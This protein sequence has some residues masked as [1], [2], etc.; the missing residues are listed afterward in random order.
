MA[1]SEPDGAFLKE[2]LRRLA[3]RPLTPEDPLYV[4]LHIRPEA[5][6]PVAKI[7]LLIESAALESVQLFS[8]FK[9]SGKTTELFRL[10][11]TL[12]KKGFQVLYANAVEYLD[13]G[14]EIDVS[15][16][17]LAV[18]GGFSDAL[19]GALGANL[20]AESF[21][22]R[23]GNFLTMT[24][25]Q[26]TEITAKLGAKTPATGVLGGFEAGL[27][28]KM[29]LKTTPT[30]RRKLR[31]FLAA[32]LGELKAEVNRFVEDGVKLTREKAGKPNLPIVFLFDSFDQ[33]RGTWVNEREVMSSITQLFASYQGLLHLPYVHVV[34][35]VHPWLRFVRPGDFTIT[36]LPS[37]RQWE[38]DPPRTT[39]PAGRDILRRIVAERLSAEGIPRIFGGSDTQSHPLADELIA[40]CGG[41]FRDLLRLFRELITLVLTWTCSLPVTQEVV[42]RAIVNVRRQYL[43]LALDDVAWLAEIEAQRDAELPSTSPEDVGRLTRFLDSHLVLFLGNGEDWYDIHPLI[44]EHVTE[45]ARRQKPPGE[46]SA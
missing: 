9:G 38:N 5:E 32:R 12:Q 2:I 45:Q 30:F 4:P 34:Y 40:M 20:A 24:S 43:P 7:Q 33:I 14:S 44:R 29:A 1:L 25:P 41:D 10:R 46:H 26:V 19:Q 13:T 27:D 17:L 22:Q 36:T 21:W 11:S 16:M 35:T 37:V 42:Q 8:G 6:D 3:D 39:Y 15:T 28:V 31:D 23:I 18:A